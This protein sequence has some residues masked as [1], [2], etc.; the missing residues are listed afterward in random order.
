M[1]SSR[2]PIE[3]PDFT[4]AARRLRR[5]QLV[6]DRVFDQVYPGP[7]QRLSSVHWTPVEVAMRVTR[8]L[9]TSP[10]ARILDIG[11]GVGKF[12]IV[13]AAMLPKLRVRGIEHRAHF[14]D[15]A[16]RAAEK[17]GVVVD[18]EHGT[19]D[20][21]DPCA[22]D[23]VYL[24]NPFAENLSQPEDHIDETVEV[25]EERFWRDTADVERFLDASR[26]GTR[27]VTY[28]G[29]GGV[30]PSGFELVLRESRAG[31]IELWQ[32][33]ARRFVYAQRPG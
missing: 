1:S 26:V 16:E 25:G 31:T 9:A 27:V 18:F 15:V 22:I 6:V 23:A 19:I 33:T 8:H 29:W 3:E 24:F 30:M 17:V 21:V 5:G 20:G 7:I 12:C 13:A 4:A 2:S 32:K 10:T 28:C 11:S 14:V